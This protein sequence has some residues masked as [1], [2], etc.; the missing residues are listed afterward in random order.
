MKDLL[1]LFCFPCFCK[2]LA[3]KN[4]LQKQQKILDLKGRLKDNM[5]A[6]DNEKE[7]SFFDLPSEFSTDFQDPSDDPWKTNEPNN[8]WS[9][10]PTKPAE[11]SEILPVLPIPIEPN[12][13]QPEMS[14][15][16]IKSTT[17]SFFTGFSAGSFFGFMTGMYSYKKI[18]T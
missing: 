18:S 15:D 16:C 8:S 2:S 10:D 7:G 11:E 1:L 9:F 13:T 3:K 5:A 6:P 12:Y 4:K 14:T 17:D